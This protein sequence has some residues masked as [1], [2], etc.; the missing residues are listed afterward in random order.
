MD[1]VLPLE[2][3]PGFV[4]LTALDAL[5]LTWEGGSLAMRSGESVLLPA[6]CPAVSLE[7]KGRALLSAVV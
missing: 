3:R 7:G 2:T 4:M 5:T 1:G 6:T